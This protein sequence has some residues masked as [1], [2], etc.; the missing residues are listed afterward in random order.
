LRLACVVALVALS[1]CARC[2]KE[3]EDEE[4][5]QDNFWRAQIT[6]VG[7]GSVATTTKSFDCTSDGSHQTGQCGPLLQRFKELAPPLLNATARRGWRFD[8]WESLI[9]AKDGSAAPRQGR[10]PD[11]R[12]YLNGFGYTDTGALETVTAV[13]VTSPDGGDEPRR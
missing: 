1:S 13:F 5:E 4:N 3:D 10:M 8:H 12:F 11:G 6:I 2:E 7:Q 9:R